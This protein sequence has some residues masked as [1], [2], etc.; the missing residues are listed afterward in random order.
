MDSI[1]EEPIEGSVSVEKQHPTV[2]SMPLD[3]H[4][5]HMDSIHTRWWILWHLEKL[6]L[7]DAPKKLFKKEEEKN[8]LKL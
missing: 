7:V 8:E 6:L 4:V 2:V 5:H 3:Q 1:V